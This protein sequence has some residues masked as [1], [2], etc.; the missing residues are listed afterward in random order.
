MVSGIFA[1]I[2]SLQGIHGIIN[3]HL[4]ILKLLLTKKYKTRYAKSKDLT[5]ISL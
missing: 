3:H 1:V 5:V 2:V 4:I